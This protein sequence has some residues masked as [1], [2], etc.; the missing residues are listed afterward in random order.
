MAFTLNDEVFRC[1]RKTGLNYVTVHHKIKSVEKWEK[2]MEIFKRWRDRSFRTFG[3]QTRQN[4][5]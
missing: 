2:E 3:A 4:I 5:R 1:L